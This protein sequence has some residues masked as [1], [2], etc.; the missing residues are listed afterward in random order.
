MK[1]IRAL[2]DEYSVPEKK[3]SFLRMVSGRTIENR[4]LI[5]GPTWKNPATLAAAQSSFD[6]R[7]SAAAEKDQE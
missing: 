5:L 7:F 4:S 6:K 1:F 3:I 2:A